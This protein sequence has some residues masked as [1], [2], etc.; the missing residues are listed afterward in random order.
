MDFGIIARLKNIH[1]FT[2]TIPLFYDVPRG[3]MLQ[4]GTL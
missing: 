1:R 3:T 2:D 4:Y